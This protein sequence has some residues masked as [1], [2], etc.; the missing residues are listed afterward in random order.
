MLHANVYASLMDENV[1]Q[2]KRELTTNVDVSAKIWKNIMHVKKIDFG[3][4]LM[5]L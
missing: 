2:I 3:I 4:L 1:I 5:F